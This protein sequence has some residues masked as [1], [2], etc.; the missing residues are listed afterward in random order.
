MKTKYEGLYRG[1]SQ[2]PTSYLKDNLL[3]MLK[4]KSSLLAF[5]GAIVSNGRI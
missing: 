4:D 5:Q 1:L 3:P 2:I